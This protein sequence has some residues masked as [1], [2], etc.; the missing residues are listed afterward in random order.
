MRSETPTSP[1]ATRACIASRRKNRRDDSIGSVRCS[2]IPAKI[3]AVRSGVDR[4]SFEAPDGVQRQDVP[5]L[6][7]RRRQG[8]LGRF[9]EQLL[10]E[11]DGLLAERRQGLSRAGQRGPGGLACPGRERAHPGRG[12]PE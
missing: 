10:L 8:E 2:Y 4:N 5:G 12:V 9:L 7:L 3:P 11:R 1:S 6:E